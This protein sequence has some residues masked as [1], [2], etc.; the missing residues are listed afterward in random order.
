MEDHIARTVIGIDIGKRI[1]RLYW[2]DVLT[3]QV[4]RLKTDQTGLLAFL[5]EQAPSVVAIE[6]SG[7]MHYLARTFQALGHE[8]RAIPPQFV[9][10]FVRTNKSDAAD[11]QA[12]WEAV[13]RPGIR[14]VPIKTPE[15]QAVLGLHRLR[16]G[17]VK[18]RNLLV[19]QLHG[20]LWDYGI[21]TPVGRH[22]MLP[23]AREV[24]EAKANCPVPHRL[25]VELRKQIRQIEY[26]QEQVKR[27]EKRIRAWHE[28]SESSQRIIAIPGVGLLTATAA[29]AV[30]GDAR[31]F[32]SARQFSAFLGLVPRH[33][34]TGG[35]IRMFGISRRGNVYLRTLLIHAA[36]TWLR[37][38]IKA[39]QVD[40]WL[41]KLLERR[42]K[43]VVGVALAN[44]L[45]RI[46]WAL[47][48][49][50]EKFRNPITG[51]T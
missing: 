44:K 7:P 4:G 9:R 6:A 29:V 14:F 22:A 1:F 39:D 20:L 36:R 15:Q 30:I 43:N 24:L 33:S 10:P 48:L 27:L 47:V 19:N 28:T 50:R 34:G 13:Q 23:L 46:I 3:A 42:H 11:A 40:P 12:I 32:Q 5:R 41:K 2:I 38:Q 49:R 21:V 26:L 31:A 37:S 16:Q 17:R 35:E 45:A 25:R 51:T 8:V 18:F